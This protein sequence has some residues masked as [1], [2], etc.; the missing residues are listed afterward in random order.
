MIDW[1][2]LHI[3]VYARNMIACCFNWVCFPITSAALSPHWEWREKA[4]TILLLKRKNKFNKIS[5]E[6]RKKILIQVDFP[7]QRNVNWSHTMCRFNLFGEKKNILYCSMKGTDLL[8]SHFSC[9]RG[10]TYVLIVEKNIYLQTHSVVEKREESSALLLLW[11]ST[12]D[13]NNTVMVSENKK[14]KSIPLYLW[15]KKIF[16]MCN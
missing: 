1:I 11:L 2:L 8:G 13:T 9:G 5:A 4:F 16:N 10:A 3:Q 12:A 15:R 7:F 6:A 14:D